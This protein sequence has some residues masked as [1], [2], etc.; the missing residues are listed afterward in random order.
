MS[1][2]RTSIRI[3]LTLGAAAAGL[4]YAAQAEG[5]ITGDPMDQPPPL[6]TGDKLV[7][8]D[9][10]PVMKLSPEKATAPGAKQVFRGVDGSSDT[11]IRGTNPSAVAA[12][13]S[14]VTPKP[15]IDG[16]FKT[17]QRTAPRT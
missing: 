12:G 10:R 17:G 5:V 11:T 16:H 6:F 9:G 14:A 15:A 13:A 3:A 7:E 1:T 8:F 2:R 4:L